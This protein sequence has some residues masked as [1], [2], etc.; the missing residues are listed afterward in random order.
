MYPDRGLLFLRLQRSGALPSRESCS[1]SASCLAKARHTTNNAPK[2]CGPKVQMRNDCGADKHCRTA[3]VVFPVSAKARK[4]SPETLQGQYK[5]ENNDD[6]SDR[7][8]LFLRLQATEPTLREESFQFFSLPLGALRPFQKS[9]PFA[10]PDTIRFLNRPF[11][12]N[13]A[14]NDH[15][16]RHIP[17]C[18]Q[19]GLRR[20]GAGNIP[21]PGPRMRPYREYLARI[22]VRAGA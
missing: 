22:G 12:G 16:R 8:L 7:G 1:R 17:H 5:C 13:F 4:T 6:A 20:R 10:E 14:C 11:F 15:P 2:H 21:P 9:K 3:E 19:S 18:G